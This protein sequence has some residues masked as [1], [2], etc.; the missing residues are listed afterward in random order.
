MMIESKPLVLACDAS[1]YCLRAVL[2]HVTKDGREKPEGLVRKRHA[3]YLP[4]KP[5]VSTISPTTLLAMARPAIEQT[6]S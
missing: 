2:S 6:T 1:Q 3:Q 4:E 5:I